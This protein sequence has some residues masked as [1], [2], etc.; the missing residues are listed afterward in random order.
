MVA[1]KLLFVFSIIALFVVGDV[2]HAQQQAVSGVV[3]DLQC[4]VDL[5]TGSETDIGNL[6]NSARNKLSKNCG[7]LSRTD[8]DDYSVLDADS[9]NIDFVSTKAALMTNAC[10]KSKVNRGRTLMIANNFCSLVNASPV[11]ACTTSYTVIV[12]VEVELGRNA[13]Y[14]PS[15]TDG[16]LVQPMRYLGIFLAD[17]CGIKEC[18][19]DLWQVGSST[20]ID[21][22]NFQFPVRDMFIAST[23]SSCVNSNTIQVRKW[24]T[25]TSITQ[26]STC[27]GSLNNVDFTSMPVTEQRDSAWAGGV[28]ASNGL[29][30]AVP[31]SSTSVAIIDPTTDT[32]DTTTITGLSAYQKWWGGVLADNGNIYSIPYSSDKLLIIDPSTNTVDLSATVPSDTYKWRG[33]VLGDDGKVYGIPHNFNF[34]LVVDP[35]TNVVDFSSIAVPSGFS[36]WEGGVKADS[37]VVYAIPSWAAS[38]LI[39]TPSTNT[40]DTTTISV[41]SNPGYKWAGGALAPNGKIYGIP[42]DYAAVLIIDTSTNTADY[43]SITFPFAFSRWVGGVL[44]PDGLIYGIPNI[45]DH[46]L[47]I[48]PETD[49]ADFTTHSVPSD[50]GK[51]SGGVAAGTSIY[52]IPYNYDAVLKIDFTFTC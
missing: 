24:F 40:V 51:W 3:V 23:L 28:L 45:N 35:S 15:K 21:A 49:T 8:F 32:I 7:K 36:K 14:M 44:G 33:G 34:M 48:D 18:D 43:T 13:G 25:V 6:S 11:I 41:S 1:G 4:P 2:A 10:I 20:V 46:I 19:M 26:D 17:V 30:Y 38:V 29:I 42:V 5:T 16:E 22:T 50:T 52:G 9:L 27:D 31:L 47:V 37:G 39:F 12:N